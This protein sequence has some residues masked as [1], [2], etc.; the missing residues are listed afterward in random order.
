MNSEVKKA[1]MQCKCGYELLV[2]GENVFCQN[3]RKKVKPNEN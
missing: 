3:C 1:G 2:E